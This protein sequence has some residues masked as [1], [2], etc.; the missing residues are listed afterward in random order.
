M[1]RSL[2]RRVVLP[3]LL[4]VLGAC[5]QRTTA[6][7]SNVIPRP[8]ITEHTRVFIVGQEAT[9]GNHANDDGR[10]LDQI[11]DFVAALGP[12]TRVTIAGPDTSRTT[13]IRR[14][15]RD[16]LG[17]T[18]LIGS[19][20]VIPPSSD[21]AL[22][23]ITVSWA[24]VSVPGCPDWTRSDGTSSSRLHSSNFGCA[25]AQSLAAMLHEP[26]DLSTPTVLGPAD[27]TREALAIDRYRTDKVKEPT[28]SEGFSP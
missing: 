1:S 23:A 22:T 27:G 21:R 8:I 5:S 4:L 2:L 14:A 3:A 16:R 25:N 19:R 11:V 12:R 24:S 13:A 17:A 20:G 10:W 6:D 26:L 9:N 18:T 28:G 7:P 15:L